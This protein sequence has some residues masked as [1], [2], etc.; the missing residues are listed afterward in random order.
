M[1]TVDVKEMDE[2][3]RCD[4]INSNSW[5]WESGIRN[6]LRE[7]ETKRDPDQ[8]FPQFGNDPNTRIKRE[9]CNRSKK[10]GSG[11]GR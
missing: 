2:F 7:L 5:Y 11:Y 6:E 1:K 10:K 3:I 4:N 9:F 8:V